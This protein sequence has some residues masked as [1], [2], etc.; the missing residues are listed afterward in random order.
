MG[1]S[2]S[3][4][5]VRD[6]FFL[7]FGAGLGWAKVSDDEGP[8][9]RDGSWTV[10]L[11]LGKAIG[12]R[13]LA[14][15]ELNGWF[16]SEEDVS[17]SLFD[18]TL[19]LY[20]YPVDDGVFVKGGL[21]LSRGDVDVGSET[22][23]GIGVGVMLGVGYDFAIGTSTAV[24]PTATFWWGKPGDLSIDDIPIIPGFKHNVFEIGVGITF[25]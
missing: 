6:G 25:Y 8:S 12:D 1:G 2:V 15:A 18:A 10:N 22:A 5:P 9:D 14:G 11:R 20:Y 17:V 16:E 3:A 19:A 4:Q 23:S 24:T 21:G 13:M 7:G